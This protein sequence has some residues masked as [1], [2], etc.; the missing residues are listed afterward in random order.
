MLTNW[1]TILVSACLG[2]SGTAFA[3]Q[4]LENL[5]KYEYMAKCASCHGVAA[6]GDGP[7]R[8][9]LSKA[10]PDLTTYAKRNGGAFPTELAWQVI[11]GRTEIPAHG[12]RDMPV[13]GQELRREVLKVNEGTPNPEWLVAGRISA[14]IDYLAT[15]QVK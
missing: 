11:D 7:M 6:K 5:G 13:W 8:K 2:I 4:A 9:A 3:Q 14:L 12:T 1:Q 10:P 15:I